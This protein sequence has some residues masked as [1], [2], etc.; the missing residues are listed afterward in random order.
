M[1]EASALTVQERENEVHSSTSVSFRGST[2]TVGGASGRGDKRERRGR[3]I[4]KEVN[5]YCLIDNH[6]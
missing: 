5:H 4:K 3:G 2:M 1:K 6:T